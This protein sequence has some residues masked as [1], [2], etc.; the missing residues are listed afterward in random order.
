MIVSG[1]GVCV[2]SLGVDEWMCNFLLVMH[3]KLWRVSYEDS[4]CRTLIEGVKHTHLP[5]GYD[6]V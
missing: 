2:I 4:F 6:S 3:T 5:L 1:S